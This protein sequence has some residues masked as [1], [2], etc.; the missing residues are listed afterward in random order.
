MMDEIGLGGDLPVMNEDGLGGVLPLPMM[1]EN[2]IVL[3]GGFG[4]GGG[5]PPPLPLPRPTRLPPRTAPAVGGDG[6]AEARVGA[7]LRRWG[8]NREKMEGPPI[9]A[10][11]Q[12][13]GWRLRR[14]RAASRRWSL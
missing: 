12:V 14:R 9:A 2:R 13:T 3:D 11:M 10:A 7:V 5:R 6:Q 8:W 4:L 1:D